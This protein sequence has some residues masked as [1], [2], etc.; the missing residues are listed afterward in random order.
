MNTKS[1]IALFIAVLGGYASAASGQSTDPQPT[2]AQVAGELHFDCVIREARARAPASKKTDT[3]VAIEVTK[4]CAKEEKQWAARAVENT[5]R[6]GGD[7]AITRKQIARE[8]YLNAEDQVRGAR[9]KR[10]RSGRE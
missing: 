4:L 7:T 10:I 1:F 6:I 3:A 5:R 8:A 2:P 9:G